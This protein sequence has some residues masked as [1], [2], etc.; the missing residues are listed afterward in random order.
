MNYL[1]AY[2]NLIRKAENRI[3]P[4]GYTE[5]HHT[6]PKSIFGNNNRLVV[7]TAREHYVA[8]ALLEKIYI[9][10][11]GEKNQNSIKM[12]HAFFLM[13]SKTNG[14]DYRNS[15]LYEGL[16]IR[17][18]KILS[19]RMKQYYKNNISPLIGRK[20]GEE[21]KKKL[22]EINTGRVPSDETRRK[23]SEAKKGK[24]FHTDEAKEKIREAR[25]KQVFSEET[26][27]KRSNTLKQMKMVWMFDPILRKNHRVSKENINEKLLQGFVFGFFS[28]IT[29][30]TREKLRAAANKRWSNTKR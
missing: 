24:T 7:L 6:F 28:N 2:C 5:K 30:E 27:K 18:S 10:R 29:D 15:Y 19:D 1:K 11:Y 9:K 20:M 21:H 22:I 14:N 16:R 25:A 8:H 23:I 26:N 12:T 3:P 17:R 4:E 13:N